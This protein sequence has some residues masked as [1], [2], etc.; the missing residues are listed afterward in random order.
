V[1]AT[2]VRTFFSPSKRRLAWLVR[3]IYVCRYVAD[4]ELRRRERRQ[5]NEDESL[6]A[7]RRNLFFAHQG[8]LPTL[9]H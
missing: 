9:G 2:L 7:L 6:H 1:V 4:E 3:T 5:L 8:H